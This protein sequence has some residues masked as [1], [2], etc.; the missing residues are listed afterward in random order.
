M[1]ALH[2]VMFLALAR[3]G[4]LTEGHSPK[5]VYNTVP[6][7]HRVHYRYYCPTVIILFILFFVVVVPTDLLFSCFVVCAPRMVDILLE[8][9][10]RKDI[11]GELH[12]YTYYCG[13]PGLLLL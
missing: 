2:T 10:Q 4:N 6:T 11:N 7:A 1:G 12:I 8:I 9:S 13:N 3:D 5:R